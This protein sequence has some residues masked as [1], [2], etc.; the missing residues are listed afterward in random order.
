M[1]VFKIHPELGVSHRTRERDR[2]E[3]KAS[4]STAFLSRV[5]SQL[6]DWCFCGVS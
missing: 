1:S 6:Q 4:L 3:V 5:M 2:G